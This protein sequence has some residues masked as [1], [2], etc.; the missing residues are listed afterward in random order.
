[1]KYQGTI[2][3]NK[4]FKNVRTKYRENMSTASHAIVF[5]YN[6]SS[7]ADIFR[8]FFTGI[9]IVYLKAFLMPMIN[10]CEVSELMSK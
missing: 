3:Q 10:V 7:Y 1:M 8:Q 4:T 9:W 5:N 6:I 2:N